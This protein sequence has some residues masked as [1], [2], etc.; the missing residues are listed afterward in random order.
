[1]DIVVFSHLRWDFVFQ[2][3]QHLLTR[4]ASRGHRVLFIEEAVAGRALE[5]PLR[6]VAPNIQVAQPRVPPEMDEPARE[7]ALAQAVRELTGTWQAG[8]RVVWHYDVMSE[9]LSRGLGADVTVFDCMDELSAFAGAPPEILVREAALLRRAGV[10]FAGGRSLWNH[11]RQ[12]HANVHLFPSAVDVRHFSAARGEVAEP[13]A[14]VGAGRPRF[15]YTGVI[16]ERIDLKLVRSLAD[17]GIGDVVLVGPTAK[18]DPASV[19]SG[20]RIHSLGMQAY[21]ALPAILGNCDVGIMPFARNDATRF[22][23][24]TKT[25]EYLA[26]GL[27]VVSTPIQDVVDDYG[28]LPSV[29]VAEGDDFVRACGDALARTRGDAE[30]DLRLARISWDRTWTEMER[31]INAQLGT[32]ESVA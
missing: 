18:I 16:D 21:A 28:D 23:S 25:P 26:A 24:P 17:A 2:R 14:L 11:K 15:V 5:M 32:T 10:V 1:M 30:A 8:T 13:P 6:Q 4:A 9:P 27:P 3:P 7:R 31:N 19:P 22:I 29:W 12:R 20:P